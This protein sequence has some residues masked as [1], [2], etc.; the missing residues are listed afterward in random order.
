MTDLTTRRRA[1]S[2]RVEAFSDGVF[3]IAITL[4]VLELAVPVVGGRFAADLLAEGVAYL[5]YLAAFATIGVLWMGH[6]TVFTRIAA[7]DSGL[8]WRNLVL[9]L[10]VSVVPFPTA[11][12][13]SAYRVGTAA[14][15]AAAVVAYA[16]VGMASGVAWTLLFSY[17]RGRPDLLDPATDPRWFR[18]SESFVTLVGYGLAAVVGWSI[19]PAIALAIFL[20]FPV[21]Y[22]IRVRADE[23]G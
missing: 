16:A 8:L 20:I 18:L 3:S 12:I 22:V 17:L 21:L 23:R 1:E 19:S 4:L 5:A 15:Q 11:V 7:V 6:H 9:L 13:A 14:D 10:T 2:S